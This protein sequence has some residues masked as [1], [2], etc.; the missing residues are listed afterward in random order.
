MV[1][2]RIVISK[3][4]KGGGTEKKKMKMKM[5]GA[6]A[7]AAA[8][9]E[10]APVEAEAAAAAAE[11]EEAVIRIF[12]GGLGESVSS[13]DLRN[14]FSSNKSLGLGIQSVEIIRSKGRSFAYIDFFS[15]SNNSLSKLFNTVFFQSI[16]VSCISFFSS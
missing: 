2:A 13:E 7:A 10:P 9:P 4:N 6:A 12:V 16:S 8:A 11:E 1:E 3:Q 14:I 15:S 5:N